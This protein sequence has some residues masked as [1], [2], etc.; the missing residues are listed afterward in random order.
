[1]RTGKEQIHF[2][3]NLGVLI[4]EVGIEWLFVSLAPEVQKHYN[5]S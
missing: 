5:N 1:M 4:M 2:S 3:S